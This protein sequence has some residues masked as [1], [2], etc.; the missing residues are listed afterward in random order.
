MNTAKE[1]EW[2]VKKKKKYL[3]AINE[4]KQFIL[5]F[6]LPNINVFAKKKTI[7]EDIIWTH[8]SVTSCHIM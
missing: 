2:K 1:T 4:K 6:F 5:F 3:P 8:D 7:Q